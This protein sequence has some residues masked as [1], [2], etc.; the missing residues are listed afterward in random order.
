MIIAVTAWRNHTDGAFIRGQLEYWRGPYPLHVRVG[1]ATGGDAIVLKWCRDNGISHH[2][3]AADWVQFGRMAG[4]IRNHDMLVGAGDPVT[5]LT[6][7]LLGFPRTDGT[8]SM[9]PGSGTFG[10]IVEATLLG[11]RVEIPAYRHSG[12]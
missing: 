6:D 2:V 7:L 9:I 1:D 11:I 10:C 12:D 5:G 3:F 8:R 4:P